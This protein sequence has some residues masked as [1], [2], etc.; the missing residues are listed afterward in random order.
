MTE[1]KK[2]FFGDMLKSVIDVCMKYGK[3]YDDVCAE[4]IEAMNNIMCNR[5][6]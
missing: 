2:S 3:E 1:E 5:K 4:V 6:R